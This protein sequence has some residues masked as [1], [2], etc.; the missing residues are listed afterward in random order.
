MAL[1]LWEPYVRREMNLKKG[2]V[3]IDIGAHIGYYTLMAAK[4]VG[5]KGIVV[6][7][8][9]DPRN[10]FVLRKNIK[11]NKLHNVTICNFALSSSRGQTAMKLEE[12]PLFSSFAMTPLETNTTQ[13]VVKTISLDE[14]CKILGIEH[15]DWLKID[16]EDGASK[17][18]QGGIETLGKFPNMII[19][20]PDDETLDL[21]NRL[22]Y[23]IEQLLP[24]ESRY[25]Y[26]RCTR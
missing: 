2:D 7:I 5:E 25:G 4:A 22:G 3:V 18:L 14:L 16:V 20:V 23:D 11:L 10:L 9:P 15:V 8:E 13:L 21:L 6:S 19:E 1:G 26:Y 17:V 24:S 12:N